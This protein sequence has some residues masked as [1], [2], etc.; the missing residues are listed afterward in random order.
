M[1]TSTA[2]GVFLIGLPIAFNAL[3]AMLAVRFDYPQILREPTEEVLL[4]FRAGGSE[5]VLLWWLFAMTAVLMAPL[6]VLLAAVLR[7]ADGTLLLVG[8][9]VGV[10]AALVQF[11]GLVRWP[12]LVPHL[13]R[14][15]G[16]P[17]ASPARLEAVDVV[18]QSLNRYLGVGL[19][20]HLGYLLTG[21]WSVL[22]GIAMTQS[23]ATPG[24]FGAIGI[25]VGAA[26][27]VCSLEFVGRFESTGWELAAKLTPVTYFLWSLW[28]VVT[29][30]AVL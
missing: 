14:E 7:G 25:V 27:I 11:L 6:V 3:F 17:A 20:E 15:A 19:G 8:T 13:A 12:F 21:A 22:A 2:A 28:L 4:R 1:S 18:F 23:S 29:G 24:F 26:L 30:F 16:D 10:L 5:L 9:F